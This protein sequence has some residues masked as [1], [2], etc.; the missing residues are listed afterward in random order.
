MAL[1]YWVRSAVDN[2]GRWHVVTAAS[3]VLALGT[4]CGSTAARQQEAA[5]PPGEPARLDR[6][7]NPGKPSSPL[8]G[9]NRALERMREKGMATGGT[10][11]LATRG[12]RAYYRVSEGC[13]GVGPA[14]PN[15]YTLGAVHCPRSPQFPSADLPILD[16]TIFG[17]KGS[18]DERPT[19]LTVW[20]GEGIAADGVAKVAWLDADGRAV[21][22]TEVSEN[23][24]RFDPA[25]PGEAQS[26]VAYSAS[27]EIV[28][29]RQYR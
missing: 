4:S 20:R 27:G 21:A 24:Y 29:S 17:G 10:S 1:L 11:L 12:D 3:L 23:V 25:P 28:F 6:V 15:S 26:L 2:R 5:T 14:P 9:D 7:S 8:P 13:Y 22:E 16:L 18:S 19:T